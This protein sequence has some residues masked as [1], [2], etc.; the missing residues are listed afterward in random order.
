LLAESYLLYMSIKR[1]WNYAK[2]WSGQ[3]E[4]QPKIW[5]GPWP[6]QASLRTATVALS[7]LCVKLSWEFLVYCYI[8]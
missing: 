1:T 8:T 4:G 5:E 2:N 3:A 6:T 7:L